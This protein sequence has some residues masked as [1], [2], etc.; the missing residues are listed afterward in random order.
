MHALTHWE[1]AALVVWPLLISAVLYA[2]GLARL[3]RKAGMGRG[4]PYWAALCFAAGWVTLVSA[5]VSPLAWVSR[6]LF[7][8]H[9]T[10]HTLLM[11]VAAPL[12]TFG[13]PLLVWLWALPAGP[14]EAVAQ[15]CHG[16][17]TVAAWRAAT[18]PLI[19]FLVHAAVLWIWHVPRLYEG[20]LHSDALHAV[21]HLCLVGAGALFW[22]AMVY[23]RYG[24]RGY[25]LSVLY[26]F[27][28]AV[29]SSVL[30]AL[31]AVSSQPWY[32][33]Y[34]RQAAL[35]HVSALADQQL[36]GLL[37]WVPAGT[38]FILLGL[39]LFAAWLG[40]AERRVR[41]GATDA[42]A[43]T[44][45]GLLAVAIALSTT[46]CSRSVAE[47]EVLTGGHA[48]QGRAELV[49][50]GCVG[51]HAVPGIQGATATVAVPLEGV[52][53]RQYLAGRLPNT[54][55]NMARWIQHPQ[56]IAPGTAMPELGVGDQQARDITA[57]LYSLR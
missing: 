32:G 23:G 13:H 4:I 33:E 15:A 24:R 2:I 41:F 48:E 50:F 51:C 57:Y 45:L 34:G 38:V 12:L 35:R 18:S 53:M 40:E 36:A 54:P 49:R 30:G 19:V 52:A 56:A 21:Q 11:L 7:S 55:D 31:L 47:A 16:E 28:T 14:R 10:Q 26:V 25:G 43:R 29:H 37:M 39:G 42:A 5:L 3:W 20:A 1:F 22:W 17:R 46:G 6:I 8:A 27:L 44:L 9:M